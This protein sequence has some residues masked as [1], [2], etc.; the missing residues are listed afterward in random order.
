MRRALAATF[1]IAGCATQ[2]PPKQALSPEK[3]TAI[4]S[5]SAETESF[6]SRV[7]YRAREA[8]DGVGATASQKAKVDDLLTTVS[9]DLYAC[10][11]GSERRLARTLSILASSENQGQALEAL[12]RADI[13][14]SDKCLMAGSDL[15][16]G[17]SDVLTQQQ[18]DALSAAWKKNES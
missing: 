2:T 11:G 12:E 18:R 8:L 6:E 4:A 14:L 5:Q 3:P 17:F 13:P 7:R 9:K 16:T 15:I 1:L 10:V